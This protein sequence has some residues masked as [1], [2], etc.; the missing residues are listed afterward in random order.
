MKSLSIFFVLAF[1]SAV[2][3]LSPD[4]PSYSQVTTCSP[5]CKEDA[6]CV[7]LGGK[8]CPN[9][10]NAKSCVTKGNTNKSGDNK[11]ESFENFSQFTF[12]IIIYSHFR[13]FQWRGRQF[14][15]QREVQLV[16]K[17]RHGQNYKATKVR[18][19]LTLK[20]NEF[21]LLINLCILT[22]N[23]CPRQWIDKKVVTEKTK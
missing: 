18:S 9:L 19:S 12:M 22:F 1:L 15:R 7:S 4:C 14:L 11:C 20:F 2:I 3:A 6:E 21:W 16:W 10:C 5:K 17:M 8:C 13:Q 23:C